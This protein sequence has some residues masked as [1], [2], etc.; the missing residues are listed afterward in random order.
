MLN[1]IIFWLFA[2]ERHYS[3]VRK[4]KLPDANGEFGYLHKTA[5]FEKQRKSHRSE[6]SKLFL[7]GT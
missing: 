5:K 3:I 7:Q 4:V 6:K 2:V 1:I